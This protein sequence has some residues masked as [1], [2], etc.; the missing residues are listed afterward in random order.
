MNT[1]D[2]FCFIMQNLTLNL[3]IFSH[4]KTLKYSHYKLIFDKL[5][6][7]PFGIVLGGFIWTLEST[8]K[9]KKTRA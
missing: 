9:L 8:G 7:E 5:F 3:Q 1:S 4:E 2:K 6:E